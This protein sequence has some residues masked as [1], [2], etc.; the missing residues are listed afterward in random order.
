LIWVLVIKPPV[1]MEGD[2][3]LCPTDY[4]SAN[5]R[6]TIT[7][8]V[9]KMWIHVAICLVATKAIVT[10]LNKAFSKFVLKL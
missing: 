7:E 2:V 10:A 4:M 1:G 9:A 3:Y 6:P 8:R 5:V